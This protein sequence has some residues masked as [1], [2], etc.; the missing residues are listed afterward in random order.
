MAKLGRP[1]NVE[2][3]PQRRKSETLTRLAQIAERAR[4]K[5][6]LRMW[7][8]AT[9]ILGYLKGLSTEALA[10]QVDADRSTLTRWIAAYA[11][12]GFPSLQPGKSTGRRPKLDAQQTEALKRAIEAGPRAAGFDSAIWTARAVREHIQR[13]FGV[14]FNWKYVPHLLHDIGFSVQRPRKLLS[15]ADKA[16]QADWLKRRLPAIKKKPDE[17]L[18]L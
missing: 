11:N 2:M 12:R 6:D 14:E 9:S 15:R 13:A 16:A 5:N 18:D 1:R 7:A 10:K 8:K 4:R 17:L 3:K